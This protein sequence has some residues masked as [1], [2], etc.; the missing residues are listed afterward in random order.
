[1]FEI[2]HRFCAV[3]KKTEAQNQYPRKNIG[4]PRNL[5]LSTYFCRF[6]VAIC[7]IIYVKKTSN[8]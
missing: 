1:V 2:E 5:L 4:L 3:P 8:G 6:S 7:G